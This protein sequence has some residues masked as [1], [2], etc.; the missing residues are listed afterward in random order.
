M[1]KTVYQNTCQPSMCCSASA[2]PWAQLCIELR[3]TN[4]Y[5]QEAMLSVKEEAEGSIF[6]T[7]CY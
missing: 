1:N 2:F 6:C 7:I 4:T 5:A 3:D